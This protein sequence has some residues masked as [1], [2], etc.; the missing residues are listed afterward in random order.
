LLELA[1]NLQKERDNISRFTKAR[2][3]VRV[4]IGIIRVFIIVRFY[5]FTTKNPYLIILEYTKKSH[6]I[7]P[8]KV[9]IRFSDIA[10]KIFKV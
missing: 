2:R 6:D 5:S 8:N 9:I 3:Y 7:I 1:L 10:C 4:G